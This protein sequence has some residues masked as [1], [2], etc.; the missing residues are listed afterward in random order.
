MPTAP[1]WPVCTACAAYGHSAGSAQC[2]MRVARGLPGRPRPVR[3]AMARRESTRR[4][5]H[6]SLGARRSVASGGATAKEVEQTTALEHPRRRGYPPGMGVEAIA[7]R[8]SLSTGRGRKTGSVATF[9][10]EARAL[11]VGGGPAMGRR[12]R[13]VG[14]TL[15]G[16]KSGKRGLG[17]RSPW[18]SSRRRRRPDSDGR[19]QTRTTAR[20]GWE[21][22]RRGDGAN[23][24]GRGQNGCQ[25]ADAR[26]RQSP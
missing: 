18:T 8:S 20:S 2:T 11:V 1:A 26:S 16:R 3:P 4:S 13:E 15:H 6:R 12:E 9:S 25:D 19:L 14:S 22:V 24:G 7:H 10:D 23:S 5:G 17:H 21:R